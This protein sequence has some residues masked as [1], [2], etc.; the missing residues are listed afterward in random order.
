MT[1]AGPTWDFRNPAS[2]PRLLEAIGCEFDLLFALLADPA[3]WHIPTACTGWEV[4]DI[5]GHLLDTTE[6]YVAAIDIARQGGRAPAA[7]GVANMAA[8][9]DKAARAFRA[10]P[11]DEVLARLRDKSARLLE[12]FAS[13]TGSEWTELLVPEPYLGPLPVMILIEGVLAGCVVHGWDVREG[14]GEPHVPGGDAAD[15]LVPFTF[16]LWSATADVSSVDAPYTIG[17][18]TTGPNGGDTRCD[19]SAGGVTFADAAI[20]DCDATLEFDPGTLVLTAYGRV[21]A[22]T[23]R[24]DRT[25]ATSFRSLFFPI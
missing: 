17:I 8:E 25:L 9:S 2:K 24:G 13:V 20:D 7:L 21:N 18:R 23:V 5:A 3:H 14:L 10:L 1:P 4:R 12:Q 15:L 11:R 16:L 22:G 19:V 6:S